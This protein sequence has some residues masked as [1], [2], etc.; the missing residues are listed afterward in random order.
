MQLASSLSGEAIRGGLKDQLGPLIEGQKTW[1]NIISKLVLLSILL[2]VRAAPR[3]S[4]PSLEELHPLIMCTETTYTLRCEHLT[5]R[6][7]YCSEAS[8][9]SKSS[10]KPRKPCKRVTRVTVPYPPPPEFGQLSKCPLATCP[11]EQRGGNWNCCWCGKE[12]ND[13]GRCRCIMIIDRQEYRCEH[14]CCDT[15]EA[16]VE[17]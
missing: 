12:W 6:I 9:S 7:A 17:L 15:C 5:S 16:A 8:P 11:F 1:D 2:V 13:R 3:E 10:R 14:I 4:K